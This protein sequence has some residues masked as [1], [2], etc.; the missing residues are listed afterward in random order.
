VICEGSVGL[1]LWA[2]GR[3]GVAAEAKP[4]CHAAKSAAGA[5]AAICCGCQRETMVV[6]VEIGRRC[7]CGGSLRVLPRDCVG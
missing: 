7:E 4:R 5:N 2:T 1:V 6:G 3:I